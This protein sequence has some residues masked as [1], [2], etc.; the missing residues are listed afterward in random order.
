MNPIV[1]SEELINS[2]L[3]RMDSDMVP[4]TSSALP[5][6]EA[7]IAS[8][9][10]LLLK[11]Q[12]K[13]QAKLAKKRDKKRQ[14]KQTNSAVSADPVDTPTAPESSSESSSDDDDHEWLQASLASAKLE[15]DRALSRLHRPVTDAQRLAQEK[16]EAAK[17]KQRLMT[18]PDRPV[19]GQMTSVALNQCVDELLRSLVQFQKRAIELQSQA[20]AKPKKRVVFFT[21]NSDTF[22][23][24][25]VSEFIFVETGV[26]SA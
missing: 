12:A 6:S 1:L 19:L 10:A 2:A 7:S 15:R 25:F 14:K 18:I 8:A 17:R 3:F 9:E 21:L 11:Q 23:L 24:S 4:S 16:V 5:T 26:W 13:Q 22:F 20:K